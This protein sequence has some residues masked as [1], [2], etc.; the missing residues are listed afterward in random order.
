MNQF[1]LC[2]AG[3]R[4]LQYR[5]HFANLGFAVGLFLL[6][7]FDLVQFSCRAVSQRMVRPDICGI[8]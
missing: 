3:A 4:R 1:R 7:Y 6:L 2:R 8:K 5:L